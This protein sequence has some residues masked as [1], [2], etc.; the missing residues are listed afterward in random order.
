MSHRIGIVS[1]PHASP[2]TLWEAMEIFRQR[3]VDTILCAGDIAGYG[4][5]LDRTVELLIESGG[6]A[7]LG[8][9]D[10]WWLAADDKRKRGETFAYMAGLPS[11]VDLDIEGIRIHM[12]HGSPPDRVM[13][14][15]RLLDE[16]GRIIPEQQLL[17]NERLASLPYEAL[18]V[19]H[20]HQVFAERFG[21]LLVVNPGSTCFNHT[22]AILFL[23]ER[24]L[25]F[26]SLGGKE[27]LL[28]WN[29]SML[30]TRGEV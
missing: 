2:G 3:E 18:I 28:S 9:H 29:F 17:W 26:V 21:N 15:I 6:H 25:E 4:S 5:D 19:G 14:G 1:D 10:L 30:R 16:E 24:K 23:P 22:C 8:N 20:T 27:P 7:V 13:N 12:V 11:T